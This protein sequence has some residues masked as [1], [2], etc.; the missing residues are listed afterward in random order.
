M[1][2]IFSYLCITVFFAS[3]LF[4]VKYNESLFTIDG[5]GFSRPLQIGG[6]E[7][8]VFFETKEGKF[9]FGGNPSA[10]LS[11]ANIDFFE[12]VLEGDK[13]ARLNFTKDGNSYKVNLETTGFSE[14]IN[15]GFSIHA[16]KDEYF[17]GIMERVVDGEQKLSWE[18]GMTE[19]M[20]MRGQVVTTVVKPTVS[21][22]CP[23]Y[24]SSRNYSVFVEGTWPGTFDFCKS[25]PNLVQITFEGPFTT[26]IISGGE[27]AELVKEH[28]LRVGP[29]IVP[30]RWAFGTYRWRDDHT[31]REKYYD[32]TPVAAPYNSEVVED[33]LMM[34]AFDIPLSIYWVDR[35]WAKGINGYDDFEWDPDRFPNAEEM[36]GW[37][38]SKNIKFML[39]IGPWIMGDMAKEAFEKGYS[40]KGQLLERDKLERALIDFS[41]PAA[42]EWWQKKGIEKMLNQ[43][44]KGF[45]MDRAEQIIPNDYENKAFDGRVS[46]EYH[47]DYPVMYAKAAHDICKLVYSD[48]FITMPRAGYTNSSRYAVFWGGDTGAGIPDKKTIPEALRS[49]IIALQKSAVIG[50]PIWGSD[51]GGYTNI[52]DHEVTARWLA[53]SCFCPIMEVGPTENKGFWDLTE[54]PHYDKQLI[55]IWR[56][57]SKIHEKMIDYS[58]QQ[59]KEAART[60]MPVARPLFLNFPKQ[61]KAWQ[62]WQTYMYGPDILVSAIWEK[63]KKQHSLYLPKSEK[64]VDAWDKKKI[65][66]G[67]QTITIDTPIY[68][69]PIFVRKDGN[70]DLGDLNK[71]Y[72]ESVK[73]ASKKPNLKKLQKNEFSKKVF[74]KQLTSN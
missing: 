50:F 66:D 38:D 13:R 62:D 1:K 63:G 73:I 33:I 39:W 59:A 5:R 15:W 10:I 34:K 11:S 69:I 25:S 54:E 45:K 72:K 2:Q 56:L 40:V 49:A 29:T 67:G 28:S 31:Q 22:Y 4:A 55:A 6:V 71:L 48:D 64:W 57:Y 24:L 58:F 47:N 68:K 74:R 12:W 27:P 20:D 37:L 8:P 18:P 23:F 42:V 3:N 60:G 43:G 41:N 46:R 35:P 16:T 52:T 44:V 21:L 19:A 9:L 7:S 51:T 32:G 53:F 30:P 36:I 26:V 61:P 65:Y 17:T 70:I 14:I